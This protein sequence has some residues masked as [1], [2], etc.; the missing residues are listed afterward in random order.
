VPVSSIRCAMASGGADD[1]G[2]AQLVRR[3]GSYSK[4]KRADFVSTLLIAGVIC[5]NTSDDRARM[6]W[7]YGLAS[8]SLALVGAELSR[9]TDQMVF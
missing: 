6:A 9:A 7:C 1:G 8:E 5:S 4:R 2:I 3:S